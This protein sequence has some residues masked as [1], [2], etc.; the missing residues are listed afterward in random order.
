[1]AIKLTRK[2][3]SF[4][5]INKITMMKWRVPIDSEMNVVKIMLGRLFLTPDKVPGGSIVAVHWDVCQ[6]TKDHIELATLLPEKIIMI[7]I[8]GM[9][10][11]ILTKIST[12]LL[13][14]GIRKKYGIIWEFFPT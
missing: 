12:E 4:G 10:R 1:M 5:G 7:M 6:V 11:F 8:I 14:E 2:S 13:R 9:V 3:Q